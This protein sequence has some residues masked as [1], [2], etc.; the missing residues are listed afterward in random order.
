MQHHDHK[1]ICEWWCE[2]NA[3]DLYKTDFYFDISPTGDIESVSGLNNLKEAL[4][5]RLI[6]TP[7]TLV[8]R[9]TYG[10]GIKNFL[11]GINSL[12]KK[13][14]LALR[15]QEQFVQDQRVNKILGVQ[16]SQDKANTDLVNVITR[17]DAVGIGEVTFS[18]Q[19]G[20]L[21]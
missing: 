18:Y 8:H 15:I 14:Q 4:F 16:I 3:G 10:V 12:G 5:R 21:P 9:P 17:V 19:V 13:R 11:N 20:D 6:T 7:G 1:S 2:V